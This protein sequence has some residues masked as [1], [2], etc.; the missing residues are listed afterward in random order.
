MNQISS[1]L[2]EEYDEDNM[3]KPTWYKETKW[4]RRES[5]KN[6]LSKKRVK[7]SYWDFAQKN[8]QKQLEW[9]SSKMKDILKYKIKVK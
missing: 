1:I 3:E 5:K 9:V 4:E 7:H 2:R 8:L 6:S